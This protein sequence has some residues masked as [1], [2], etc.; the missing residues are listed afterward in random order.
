MKKISVMLFLLVLLVIPING[1][2]AA[3]TSS[4]NDITQ[5]EVD[6]RMEIVFAYLNEHGNDA[7]PDGQDSLVYQIP[8][9]DGAIVTAEVSNREVLPGNPLARTTHYG[10]YTSTL[11]ANSN[12]VFTLTIT[13]V[14]LGG[15]TTVFTVNYATGNEITSG[16]KNYRLTLSNPA[17]SGSTTVSGY[18]ATTPQAASIVS[19]NNI[20]VT[21]YGAM[22][23]NTPTTS[24]LLQINLDISSQVGGV[25]AALYN[26]SY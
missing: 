9:G 18:S 5:D 24:V 1:A 14:T 20:I 17:I 16:K 10:S 2:F 4:Q 25:M 6:R 11:T 3:A 19:N 8:V 13:N 21:A 15:D 22:S 7:I 26:Y 12:Y 23:Y